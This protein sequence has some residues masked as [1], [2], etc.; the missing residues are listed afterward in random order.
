MIAGD[1][2]ANAER[3][4]STNEDPRCRPRRP[5]ALAVVE[6]PGANTI[7]KLADRPSNIPR[8]ASTLKT[9]IYT[10][11]YSRNTRKKPWR[12]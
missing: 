9:L 2:A 4:V 1:Y 5:R 6:T 8:R 7:A 12:C 3:A 11:T 10:A